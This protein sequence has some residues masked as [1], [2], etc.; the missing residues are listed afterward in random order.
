MIKNLNFQLCLDFSMLISINV[1]AY[2]Y[3]NM[4][5]RQHQASYWTKTYGRYYLWHARAHA[6]A[7]AHTEAVFQQIVLSYS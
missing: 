2:F 1:L 7:R 6:H 3:F 5:T 4:I